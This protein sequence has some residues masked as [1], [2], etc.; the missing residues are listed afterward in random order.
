MQTSDSLNRRVYLVGI[1]MGNVGTLT[2]AGRDAIAQSQLVIGADRVLAAAWEAGLCQVD[3]ELVQAK[4]SDR[5]IDQVLAS[6]APCVSILFSGDTGFYS[7]ATILGRKL[8][9]LV[10]EGKLPAKLQVI[11]GVSSLSYFCALLGTSWQDAF[12]VSLH[13]RSGNAAGAVQTHEKTFFLTGGQAKAQDICREL[14]RAGLGDVTVSAGENL[15]YPSERVVTGTAAELARMSFADLT[16]LLAHNEQ[17]VSCPPAAPGLPDASFLRDSHTPM[18]KE[19]IRA[20]VISKLRLAPD[21]LVWDVGAGTGSVS[22]E[23]ALAA[24]WGQVY[25]VERKDAALELLE[26]NRKRFGLTNLHVV[27][28]EAPQALDG[29][30]APDRVFVGG[31]AGGFAEIVSAALAANPSARIVATCITLETLGVALAT[32]GGEGLTNLEV[33]QVSVARGREAGPYH[34]MMG[35]NP[36]YI[37][38][39]DGAG[40]AADSVPPDTPKGGAHAS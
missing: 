15:S 17:P 25:A 30:P 19:E 27:A 29:L 14:V 40:I 2:L 37:L 11:P 26:Q 4:K 24:S 5:I 3:A 33:V 23:A 18:T 12:V 36:V 28:G 35:Q 38:S 1:G 32:L 20:L 22:V 39:A 34:L 8:G 9:A 7:G 16:V 10:R 31:S 21:S 6:D 13:G